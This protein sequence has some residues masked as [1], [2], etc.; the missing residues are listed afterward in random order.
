MT[1]SGYLMLIHRHGILRFHFS[2]SS[3]VLIS[4]KK[5]YQVRKTVFNHISKHCQVYQKSDSDTRRIFNSLL[6]VRKWV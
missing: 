6:G 3:L 5:I 4:F 1:V 2:V